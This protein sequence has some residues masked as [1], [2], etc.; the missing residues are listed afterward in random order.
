MTDVFWLEQTEADLPGDRDWLSANEAVRAEGMRFAKRRADW[1]LGRWT[2]KRAVAEYWKGCATHS[3]LASIEIR[4]AVS[5]APEVFLAGEMASVAISLSHRAG[6][7]VCAVASPHT[8]LG[9]DLEVVE[10]RCD[11]FLSDYFTAGEQALVTSATPANQAR[12]VTLLWSAKESALKALGVGLRLDTRCVQ[13]SSVDAQDP[14]LAL[15]ALSDPAT[16]RPLQVRY[17][18]K[19]FRGSWQSTDNLLRTL[20]SAPPP[21]MPIST[22]SMRTDEGILAEA[23]GSRTHQRHCAA[24]RV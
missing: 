13:V 4:P 17:C 2:A 21:R 22:V 12:V 23:S 1:L 11:A 8:A 24:Q 5:G 3:M 7:A 18:G 9:C 15:G 19:I 6:R 20:V 10:P 16:W 14:E